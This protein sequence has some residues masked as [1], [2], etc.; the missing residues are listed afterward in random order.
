M[1]P[2]LLTEGWASPSRTDF[3][4]PQDLEKEPL[5]R[6][7]KRLFFFLLDRHEDFIIGIVQIAKGGEEEVEGILSVKPVLAA[8]AGH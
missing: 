6:V 2:R 1:L 4:S 3:K 5:E 8:V 7:F